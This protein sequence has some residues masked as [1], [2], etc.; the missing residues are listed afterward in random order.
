MISERAHGRKPL[1]AV[2]CNRWRALPA[3]M[4]ALL[5]ACTFAPLEKGLQ[6]PVSGSFTQADG[7][8]NF[9]TE[10]VSPLV[11]PADGRYLYALNTADDRL[12][13]FAAMAPFMETEAMLNLK[14]LLSRYPRRSEPLTFTCV[15]PG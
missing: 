14:G 8:T 4:L 1:A 15:P 9:D 7:F 3:M 5:A 13:I 10:P 11:L 6:T 2:R 12:E